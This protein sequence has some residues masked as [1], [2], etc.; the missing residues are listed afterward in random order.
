MA[1]WV[2]IESGAIKEY[3]DKLPRSWRNVSGLDKASSSLLR[4]L[5]WFPV[6]KVN[7]VVDEEN[8]KTDGYEYTIKANSVEEKVKVV[9]LTKKEKDDKAKK[10]D[11][12]NLS[13][14]AGLRF[15]RDRLLGLTD[16][17]QLPDVIQGK[18]ADWINSW[19]EYR[20]QLRDLPQK[21]AGGVPTFPT[22]PMPLER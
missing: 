12:E 17:T 6:N 16:W 7:V 21:Y 2:Y 14:L 20:Q 15:E 3:H 13:Q 19:R 4:S 1:N 8:F 5:G 22:P 18:D 11:E 9:A 10:K